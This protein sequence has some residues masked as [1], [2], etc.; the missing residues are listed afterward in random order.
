MAILLT[1]CSNNADE[2][3]K[4]NT[5]IV[6]AITYEIEPVEIYEL[7]YKYLIANLMNPVAVEMH[8]HYRIYV[9]DTFNIVYM[10]F[11]K[12]GNVV[13]SRQ[14][15]TREPRITVIE[16]RIISVS[17]QAG[18][19][20]ETRWTYFYDIEKNVFSQVFYAVY[21]QYG[22]KIVYGEFDTYSQS[23]AI[24]VQN[25]FD[26]TIYFQR[27]ENFEGIRS[28]TPSLPF[29]DVEF[30]DNGQRI[31]VIYMNENFD[32]ITITLDLF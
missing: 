8:P 4:L 13:S 11:D 30:I 22:N 3:T 12:N 6:T 1:A 2:I 10:L 23:H 27:F 15:N 24:I 21:Q 20:I 7:H 19:G 9:D 31:N 25:I 5:A 17:L 29:I 26:K 16:D 28:D 32:Y 14:F 18:T